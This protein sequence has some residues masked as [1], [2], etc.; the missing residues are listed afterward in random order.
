VRAVNP[1]VSVIHAQRADRRGNVQLWG[2]LGVQREAVLAATSSV[3][4]VEE[5]VDELAQV[6]GGQILPAWCVTFVAVVPGGAYPSYTEG[7]SSRDDG[8]YLR[9]DAISRDRQRFLA[10]IQDHILGDNPAAA[11]ARAGR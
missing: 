9:W 6:P 1:T 11:F 2:A 5:I 4:T 7:Y 8:F 10:W 3:V